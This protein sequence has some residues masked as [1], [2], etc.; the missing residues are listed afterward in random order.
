MEDIVCEK[1]GLIN[2]Y[3]TKKNKMHLAAYCSGCGSYIKFMPQG[4]PMLHFGKYKGQNL[5]ISECNDLKYLLWV[6]DNVRLS[7]RYKEA[8]ERQIDKLEGY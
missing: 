4:E 3:T 1:C 5:K 2:E 7:K 8:I 6:H